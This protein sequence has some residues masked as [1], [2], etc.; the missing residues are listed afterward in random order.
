MAVQVALKDIPDH[1]FINIRLAV[2]M[3]GIEAAEK[4]HEK[5]KIPIIFISGF[6]T[7]YIIKKQM[8]WIILN[9]LKSL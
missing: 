5:K 1:I 2:D 4:I 6:D 3:D 7:E 9:F 8:L